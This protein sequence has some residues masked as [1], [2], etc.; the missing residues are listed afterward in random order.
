[1][2]RGQ[3][4]FYASFA[5]AISKIKSKSA[6][7]DCY[8][9][10]VNYAICGIEPDTDSLSESAA[11]AFDLIRP[12]LDKGAKRAASG[13]AG[14][15]KQKESKSEAKPKQ[16][17]REKEREKEGE[18]EIEIE[19]E[20]PKRAPAREDVAPDSSNPPSDPL[21]DPNLGKVMTFY[22]DK[23][24][25]TPSSIVVDSVVEF[26]KDLDPDVVI[27]AMQIALDERKTSWSYINAILN[28]YVHDGLST[29]EAVLRSEQTHKEQKQ[30]ASQTKPK[31]FSQMWREMQNDEV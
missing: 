2:E 7:C 8:D 23:I 16:T 12:I 15:I 27:H 25:A 22:M 5:A 17:A 31:S 1:M 14:G 18:R 21:V 29:M 11:I 19:G 9:A 4:T 28:R 13:A 10:I 6:R 20:F 30:S 3:F 24:N 26:L